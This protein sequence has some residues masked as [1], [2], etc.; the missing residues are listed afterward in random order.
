MI[1]YPHQADDI[2]LSFALR[3]FIERK[4]NACLPRWFAIIRRNVLKALIMSLG[5]GIK[6]AYL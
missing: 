5:V 1:T 4:I 3:R 2:E 6:A